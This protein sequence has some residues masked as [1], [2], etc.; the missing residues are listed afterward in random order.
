MIRKTLFTIVAVLIFAGGIPVS[1]ASAHVL[2]TDGDIGAVLH[3]NPDDNPISGQSTD[4]VLSFRGTNGR[5]NLSG[6]RCEVVFSKDGK[7]TATRP[8]TMETEQI[9][10]DH[11]TFPA[12]GVY[13]MRIVGSPLH[14][15]DFQS[16]TLDYTIRVSGGN[17]TTAHDF[18]PLLWLGIGLAMGLV[19][20][21]TV[22]AMYADS[23]S[24]RAKRE[25][26]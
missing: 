26:E 18:P 16:F 10:N 5:F 2:K 3:I 25:K 7:T 15:G 8:L 17:T 19:L 22:P 20:L 6:C 12:P 24:V 14:T 9:S 21:S 23:I 11:Y 1:T 13:R 4:Y